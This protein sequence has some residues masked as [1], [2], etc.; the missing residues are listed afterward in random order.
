[1]S[2]RHCSNVPE[3]LSLLWVESANYVAS[4]WY[5]R[6]SVE[7]LS[8]WEASLETLLGDKGIDHKRTAKDECNQFKETC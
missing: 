4:L 1:M 5:C 8:Q 6:V 7:V 3:F 2:L